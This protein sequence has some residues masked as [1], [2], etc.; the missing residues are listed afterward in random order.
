M[1]RS[2]APQDCEHKYHKTSH[3][4]GSQHC[5]CKMG[6]AAE[7]WRTAYKAVSSPESWHA[8]ATASISTVG[9]EECYHVLFT[10]K[11]RQVTQGGL[12]CTQRNR[13]AP[14]TYA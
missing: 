5:Q 9:P 7:K 12:I 10:D 13:P 8:Q 4:L 1:A 2:A 3:M 6:D 14:L 11:Q